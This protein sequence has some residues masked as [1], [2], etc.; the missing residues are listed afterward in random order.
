MDGTSHPRSP[1]TPVNDPASAYVLNRGERAGFD[2]RRHLANARAQAVDRGFDQVLIVDADAH[3][4]ESDSWPDVVEHIED[5]VLRETARI[6]IAGSTGGVGNPLTF[7]SPRQQNVGGRIRRYQLRR[8]EQTDEPTHRDV[9]V[10][11]REMDSI[12]IDY[13]V[14]FPTPML[15][16]GMHPDPEIEVALSWAYTSWFVSDVL[17]RNPRVKTMVY[18]PFND[19]KACLRT[20]REFGSHR[21]VVGFMVTAT[22]YR[23][24]HQND[25][26]PLYAEIEA[27]G[28]P[29]G[30]HASVYQQER[31]FEGMNRFLS[32][33]ALGFVI[34]NMV[35]LT[36]LIINGIPERFPDLKIIFIESGLAWLPFLQQ[37]LDS[38]YLMRTSEAPLLTKRPSAYIAENFFYT[39]QPMELD[40]HESLAL[41]LRRINAETQ[42]LFASDYPHWDFNLPSTV[43]DLP[44]LDEATKRRILGLNAAELFGLAPTVPQLPTPGRG[45]IRPTE[46]PERP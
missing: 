36:N 30:F 46:E 5:P 39:T 32:V 9:A 43:W 18:L 11:I 4:Y 20:V 1:L 15:E 10:A 44:F 29:L 7:S 25:Y 33:H 13:Q 14:I 17:G 27:T 42:V 22:R 19:P 3:H 24:V 16:L 8:S 45:D 38:E 40:D 12:G 21:D 35:H 6:G 41:T 23:A 2:T 28:K 31:M 37:R 34:P 26:M